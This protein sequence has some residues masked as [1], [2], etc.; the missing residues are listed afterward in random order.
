MFADLVNRADIRVI[1]RR[2]SFRLASEPL[3]SLAILSHGFGKEFQR[4]EA[5]EFSVL[6]FVHDPHAPAAEL[7]KDA[8]M[9]D[10]LA[11][12]DAGLL[13]Y[14]RRMLGGTSP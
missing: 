12:H 5:I 2:R 4:N 11:D 1:Q 9:R 8:V 6:G 14:G 10:S 3:Q 7:L 13:S